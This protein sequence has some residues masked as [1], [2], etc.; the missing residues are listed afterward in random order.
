MPAAWSAAEIPS[1][2]A[3]AVISTSVPPSTART[4]HVIV[5]VPSE[6]R[7]IGHEVHGL[8]DPLV[9]DDVDE[10]SLDHIGVS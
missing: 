9:G 8:N 5:M 2:T 6:R 3:S 7:V 10:P 4:L 1:G